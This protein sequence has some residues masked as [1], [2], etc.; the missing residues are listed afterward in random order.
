MLAPSGT[1]D[2]TCVMYLR[3]GR[4]SIARI[5]LAVGVA[6]LGAAGMMLCDCRGLYLVAVG[7]MGV[8]VWA[9]TGA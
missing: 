7:L 3:H 6:T 2:S 8:A 9:G 4:N 5:S 1:S